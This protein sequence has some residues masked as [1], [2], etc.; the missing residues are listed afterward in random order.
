MSIMLLYYTKVHVQDYTTVTY[1]TCHMGVNTSA[2]ELLKA[3]RGPREGRSER[4]GVL[5][6]DLLLGV[7]G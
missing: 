6:K 1:G 4:T 3:A 2:K 7:K 5:A